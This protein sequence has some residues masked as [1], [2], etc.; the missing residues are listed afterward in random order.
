M[1]MNERPRI[2]MSPASVTTSEG[3]PTMATQKPLKRP[4][5]RPTRRARRI[6]ISMA[7][8]ASH[9]IAMTTALSPITEATERSISPLMMTKAMAST[10]MAFSIPIHHRLTWF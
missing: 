8:P 7:T 4:I 9:V 6:P 3:K 10:T 2:P 5:P 1:S